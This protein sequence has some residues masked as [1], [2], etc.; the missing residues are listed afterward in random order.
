MKATSSPLTGNL[1]MIITAALWGFAFVAQKTGMDYFGPFM[2]STIRFTVGAT[3]LVL[4]LRWFGGNK[5][6]RSGMLMGVVMGVV[7]TFGSMLQQIGIVDTTAGKSGFITAV[8]IL[9]VPVFLSFLGKRLSIQIWPAAFLVLFGLYLLSI[10][11]GDF[12]TINRGDYWVLGSSIFWALHIL[13]IEKAVKHHDPLR[14]SIVQFYVCA[15]LS[16]L[17]A[18]TFE[19]VVWGDVWQGL[20]GGFIEIAYASIASVAIAYTLQ[21]FAQRSVPS[22]HAALILSLEAVF[23]VV[24]GVW[25]LGEELTVRML[26]GFGLMF[27]GIILAQW[28]F[29]GTEILPRKHTEEQGKKT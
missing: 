23:A 14:L 8:Y 28:R 15:V 9:L 27:A 25:L 20:Q 18:Y 16:L 2:F 1:L 22:H 7:L 19:G 29:K 26:W 24:G 5:L 4:L 12:G 11:K 3:C 10:K 21:V 17:G 6:N 13:L